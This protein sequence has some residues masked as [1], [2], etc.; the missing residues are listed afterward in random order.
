MTGAKGMLGSD[1][2]RAAELVSHDVI[3][4]DLADLDVT[5]ADAVARGLNDL[6]PDAVINCAAYTDVDGA[7][8][9]LQAAMDANAD[10]ALAVSSAARAVGASVVYT[11][12]DYV[13]DGSKA[14]PYVESD[15]PRPQ[16]V[17]GQSK[18]AGEHATAEENPRHFVVRS[19]WLFGVQGKNFVAT[20]LRLA[21]DHGEVMVVRDQVGCPTY[22]AQLAEALVRLVATDAYGL[23]H[24]AAAGSCSWYELALEIFRRAGVDA[25]VTSCTGEELARPA[26]RPAYSV[27]AT[28][29]RDAIHLPEWELGLEEY[30]RER[31]AAA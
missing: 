18:L 11:S 9:D 6:R 27:L 20:M 23:H 7:E 12:T 15:E 13:F 21:A 8:D 28:E 22:T 26:P 30:L 17:Y 19:S 16:S 5:D 14:T 4:L 3:P 31:A 10:G 2:V 24:I 29:R 1:V 25:R